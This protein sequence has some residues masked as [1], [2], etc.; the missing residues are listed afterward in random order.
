VDVRTD[1]RRHGGPSRH[2]DGGRP[3]LLATLGVPFDDRAT[4]VAVDSA[5]EAGQELIVANITRLEPLWLSVRLGYD[6]LEELTPEVSASTRRPAELAASLGV[7]VERLRIRTPRPITTLLEL[8]AERR[9]GLLVFGPDRERVSRRT[10]RRSVA[11]L[12]SRA[13]CLLWVAPDAA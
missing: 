8:A 2:E 1:I 13:A 4:Y 12:R 5:V 6:A 9:P 7:V 3:V 11:T 10:Y